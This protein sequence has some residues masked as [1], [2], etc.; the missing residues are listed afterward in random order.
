MKSGDCEFGSWVPREEPHT[1]T[2]VQAGLESWR[3][4]CVNDLDST[5]AMVVGG[6]LSWG[7]WRHP[8]LSG[9]D[10]ILSRVEQRMER[11]VQ[12][13]PESGIFSEGKKLRGVRPGIRAGGVTKVAVHQGRGNL[14]LGHF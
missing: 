6:V 11:E 5:A 8:S 1:E 13:V 7:T 10:G 14:E 4:P 12:F 9:P 2:D 3:V